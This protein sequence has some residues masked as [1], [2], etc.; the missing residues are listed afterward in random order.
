[1]SSPLYD[2]LFRRTTPNPHPEPAPAVT[3]PRRSA[4]PATAPGRPSAAAPVPAPTS[5][6]SRAASGVRTRPES[7]PAIASAAPVRTTGTRTRAGNAMSRTREALLRGAA[8]AV[9]S[10]G[11]RIAMA[12]VATAAGVAKATLYNHFRTREA[13]LAALVTHEVTVLVD[14][15]AG[16]PLERALADTAI[17]IS[18]HPVRQGLAAVEPAVLARL[19]AIDET[20]EGWALARAAVAAQLAHAGRGGADTVLRWLGSF[21]VS[22]ASAT[23]IVA[24]VVVL[25]GGLPVA[26]AT[27]V[28]PA[29]VRSA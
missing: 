10:S 17:A 2:T 26:P 4:D 11:S 6:P 21:L 5:A 12:Q 16:K 15:A 29:E 3:E 9:T 25:V 24:D 22:P 28:G 18:R 8:L 7:V 27:G 14:A 13:V 23:L 19:G 1:M 20:C